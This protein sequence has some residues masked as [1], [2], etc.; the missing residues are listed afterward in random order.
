VALVLLNQETQ[1]LRQRQKEKTGPKP[2]CAEAI[3]TAKKIH[4][5]KSKKG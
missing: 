4:K 1:K 3:N 2:V 5:E